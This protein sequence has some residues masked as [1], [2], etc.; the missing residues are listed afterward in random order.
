MC[1]TAYI[2]V[3]RR[4]RVNSRSVCLLYALTFAYSRRTSS[5]FCLYDWSTVYTP[6]PYD[7][8]IDDELY[9]ELRK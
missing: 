4:Q 1:G 5:T 6:V 8:C 7:I 9:E 2:Y 3:V